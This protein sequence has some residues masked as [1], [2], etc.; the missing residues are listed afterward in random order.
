MKIVF[1]VLLAFSLVAAIAASPVPADSLA[2]PSRRDGKSASGKSSGSTAST[3]KSTTEKGTTGKGTSAAPKS[4]LTMPAGTTAIEESKGACP[5]KLADPAK[6][7]GTPLV[8]N[9]KKAAAKDS[10]STGKSKGRRASNEVQLV[11]RQVITLYH[12]SSESSVRSLW[13]NGVDWARVSANRG[14][15]HV[16]RSGGFYLGDNYRDTARFCRGANRPCDAAI[17]YEF[18]V[19]AAGRVYQFRNGKD[20]LWQA[21]VYY[22][23]YDEE[24]PD[25]YWSAAQEI[26]NADVV[27]GPID[28]ESGMTQYCFRTARAVSALHRATTYPESLSAG[29]RCSVQ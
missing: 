22:Y 18:D 25:Q 8:E 23:K 3:G 20:G 28:G 11:A 17:E 12:V 15:F 1:R 27:I 13:R 5:M 16:R 21:I 19:G 10:K 14:D 4:K 6:Q 24:I 9:T 7:A 29:R 2:Q 26:L